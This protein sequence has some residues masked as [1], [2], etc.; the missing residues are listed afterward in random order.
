MQILDAKNCRE[1]ILN[2]YFITM[3][4][5][6]RSSAV[7]AGLGFYMQGAAKACHSISTSTLH[8][9]GFLIDHRTANSEHRS[10]NIE[11]RTSN[12]EQRTANSEQRTANSEQRTANSEQRTANSEHRSANI[13]Q[14]TANSESAATGAFFHCMAIN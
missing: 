4:T 12:S 5:G 9:L 1:V 8:R 10:A 3:Q 14:R 11:Q 13:D 7:S 6:A 2:R